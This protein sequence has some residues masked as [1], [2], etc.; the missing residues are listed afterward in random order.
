[1]MEDAEIPSSSLFSTTHTSGKVV[2]CVSHW[3]PPSI[4][5]LKMIWDKGCTAC[6]HIKSGTAFVFL[7]QRP[8]FS[9]P[10]VNKLDFFSS[11]ALQ[12][13][14]NNNYHAKLAV[15]VL[16][17]KLCIGCWLRRSKCYAETGFNY[18]DYNPH[19][20]TQIPSYTSNQLHYTSETRDLSAGDLNCLCG[21]GIF[22]AAWMQRKQIF[23]SFRR[24]L[25]FVVNTLIKQWLYISFWNAEWT[26]SEAQ[27][28][29][30]G[31]W[32]LANVSCRTDLLV[33]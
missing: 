12:I 30:L 26:K 19:N 3:K 29:Y 14:Q 23:V 11:R 15:C 9:L 7:L 33:G 31:I 13:K 24:N 22:L 32:F 4:T 1:M 20:T 6:N 8:Y 18:L 27:S 25:R 10:S 5:K 28:L 17:L 16:Y 2:E 21:C